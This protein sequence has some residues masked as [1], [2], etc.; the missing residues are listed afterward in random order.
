MA[1]FGDLL[2]VADAHR[3]RLL[4]MLNE[5][6]IAQAAQH[7]TTLLQLHRLTRVLLRYTDQA[8]TGF[9]TRD[10]QPG[11]RTATRH[12]SDLLNQAQQHLSSHLQDHPD[13]T[14]EPDHPSLADCVR[15]TTLALGCGLDL[16]TS[17]IPESPKNSPTTTD[18][19]SV[20]AAGDTARWLMH[21]T[22]THAAAAGHL[23]LRAGPA[24]HP[25][26]RALLKAALISQVFGNANAT[27]ASALAL[28]RV[29][30]RL[31]P[32]GCETLTETAA[33]IDAS[34]RRLRAAEA[35]QTVTTWRYLT[36]TAAITCHISDRLAHRLALRLNELGETEAAIKLQA[37]TKPLSNLTQYWRPTVRTWAELSPHADPPS[38]GPAVDASDLIIRIGRLTFDDS[39]WTPGHRSTRRVRPLHRLAADPT[40]ASLTGTALLKA[41]EASLIITDQHYAAVND[42]AALGSLRSRARGSPAHNHRTPVVAHQLLARYEQLQHLGRTAVMELGAALLQITAQ[43]PATTAGISLIVRRSASSSRPTA[44][45]ISDF[46][47]SIKELLSDGRSIRSPTPRH[48]LSPAPA[49]L[50]RA[51]P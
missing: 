14:A 5:P 47:C 21:T 35:T 12:T 24:Q 51:Q 41:V 39:E 15:A 2:S 22:S 48:G 26:G 4:K 6:G 34:T 46:P 23:A 3:D 44:H 11:L 7:P 37:A 16:L 33:G 49:P 1:T 30:D 8:A 9:H 27:P 19:A 13:R 50:R 31:G 38:T 20:V 28:N 10:D 32:T 40:E 42:I 25:A 18:N 36:H 43:T 29:P 17:H 45:T